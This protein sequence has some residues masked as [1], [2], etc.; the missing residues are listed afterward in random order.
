[1]D[2]HRGNQTYRIWSAACSYGQ[3]PYSIAMVLEE[4]LQ[5]RPWEIMASD[6]SMRA[7]EGARS[8][9]YPIAQA[10]KIPAEYRMRYCL[11]GIGSQDGTFIVDRDLCKR[12]RFFHGN[13]IGD[14]PNIGQFDVIFL[15]NVMIYFDND[16]KRKAVNTLLSSLKRGGHLLIGHSESLNGVTDA[17]KMVSP[18]IYRKL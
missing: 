17:L 12:I 4:N 11:K 6:I 7:L 16:T 2:A 5:G 13:L 9:Q 15:R 3:E 18:S 14:A 10:E 1:V 8:G